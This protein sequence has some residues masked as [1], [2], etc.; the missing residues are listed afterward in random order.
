MP[1]PVTF[2]SPR[3]P[4]LRVFTG[5]TTIIDFV[6]G[7]YTTDDPRIIKLL[8]GLEDV[9]RSDDS[10]SYTKKM[11]GEDLDVVDDDDEYAKRQPLS[12]DIDVQE[13]VG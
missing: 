3:R 8:D 13:P 5:P 6:E 10:P 9:Y 4:T 7:A 12:R 1:N 2:L 11:S